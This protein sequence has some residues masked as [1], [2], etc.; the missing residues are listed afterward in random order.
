MALKR[1][2]VPDIDSAISDAEQEEQRRQDAALAEKIAYAIEVFTN[3]SPDIIKNIANVV[4]QL[5][6]RKFASVVSEE[7]SN[8]A[9]NM[10]RKFNSRVEP[11]I[12]RA[13]SADRRISLPNMAA[14]IILVTLVWLFIFFLMV[15]YANTKIQSD[16]LTGLIVLFFVALIFSIIAV[17]YLTKKY[18]W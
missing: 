1:F 14:Y 18:K 2:D 6:A 5:D 11:M 15:M 8:T 12:R 13:E 9:E 16:E 7:L 3:K 17:I 10:A 4:S